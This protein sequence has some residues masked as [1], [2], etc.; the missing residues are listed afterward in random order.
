[1]STRIPA[2]TNFI[3]GN[4]ASFETPSRDVSPKRQNLDALQSPR[5]HE[6]DGLPQRQS[7]SPPPYSPTPQRSVD[8]PSAFLDGAVR[9]GTTHCDESVENR[10]PVL[11][12]VP[13]KFLPVVN[14]TVMTA[15]LTACKAA[16]LSTASTTAVFAGVASALYELTSRRIA[17]DDEQ[18]RSA[19]QQQV[20]TEQNRPL[21]S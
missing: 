2:Q 21:D 12:K 6:L 4:P 13:L 10:D 16:S 14:L 3:G 15:T 19:I 17:I 20:Q 9:I 8:H 7:G 5:H 18:I 11:A 1:M